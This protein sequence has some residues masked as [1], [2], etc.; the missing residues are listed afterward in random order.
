MT[1]ENDRNISRRTLLKGSVAAGGAAL[2]APLTNLQARQIAGFRP[3]PR[4]GYGPIAPVADA[5]TGLPLLKLPKGFRYQSF[6]WTGDIMSDGTLT[7][8]RHDGMAVVDFQWNRGDYEIT[9]IRNHERGAGAPGDPL[10]FIGG[11]QAPIYDNFTL[12]GAVEG[13]GGGTTAVTFGRHGFTGSQATLGGTL[14]N[15]AGGPTPWGSWLTCEETIVRGALIGAQDHGYVYEV[16]SPRRGAAS[17]VPIKDMGF[18][19]HEAVAMDP[20]SGLFYLT[21]DNGNNSGF[22]RFTPNKRCWRIGDLEAGGTLEM[23]R[24]VDQANADLANVQTG[25]EFVVDWVPI[26][27]PNAD[28]ELFVAPAPDFPDI[29]GAGKSGPYLQGEAYGGAKFNRGEGCWYRY[30]LIYFV[31]TSGGPAGK[32]VVWVYRPPRRHQQYGTLKAL[33]VS[34]DEATADNPDNITISPRGGIL[35]CEDGGGALDDSGE[36]LFGAR[37]VGINRDGSSFIFGENNVVIESAMNDRPFVL[38][39]DYRGREFA[40]ATFSY[41]GSVLFVNIQTPGITFAIT[42][43]WR[44]GSL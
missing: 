23:L 41:L 5:T 22:Y 40:G 15:C 11:G 30:G 39:D 18:M 20:F 14:T 9:L 36:R 35:V 28:P 43:P 8:D 38:P 29:S 10:P 24:V 27:E 25:D 12:P 26:D 19:D 13:I 7:P 2:A 16:P 42:G 31:D 37:L 1:E 17:A 33:F 3:H 34:P 44:R 21:E 6:G 4:N 32:G